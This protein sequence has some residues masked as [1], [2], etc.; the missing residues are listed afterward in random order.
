[1][2]QPAGLKCQL[3]PSP[4]SFQSL[5]PS[6]SLS[7]SLSLSLSPSL[8]VTLNLFQISPKETCQFLRE[9]TRDEESPTKRVNEIQVG[10]V[11]FGPGAKSRSI[12]S[13]FV[14]A[15]GM[16]YEKLADSGPQIIIEARS[17]ARPSRKCLTLSSA[18]AGHVEIEL[19]RRN[20]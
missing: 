16:G 13:T 8:C 15:E 14:V 17:P 11:A 9:V 20:T 4:P 5:L 3:P 6:S 18:A 1:M 19:V 12:V 2:K 10:G 7:L